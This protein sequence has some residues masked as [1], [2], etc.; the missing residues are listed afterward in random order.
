MP[1]GTKEAGRQRDC[2]QSEF[3]MVPEEEEWEKKRKFEEEKH[4]NIINE[5]LKSN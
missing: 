3:I 2:E 1:R 4:V 5:E